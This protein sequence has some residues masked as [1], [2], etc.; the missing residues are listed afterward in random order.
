MASG[1]LDGTAIIWSTNDWK[2]LRTL[3][4]EHGAVNA[5]AFS[6]D[7][8]FIAL[9]HYDYTATL[10]HTQKAPVVRSLGGSDNGMITN[11]QVT[12][13]GKYLASS[14]QNEGESKTVHLWS[15]DTDEVIKK[16]TQDE[17][18]VTYTGL[19][20]NG[21]YMALAGEGTVYIY[22]V[23]TEKLIKTF[24]TNA[25]I[26]G[27]SFLKDNSHFIVTHLEYKAALW[28]IKTGKI[29]QNFEIGEYFI[30]T[31]TITADDKYMITGGEDGNVKFWSV[32]TGACLK[33]LDTDYRPIQSV[34]ISADSNY[35]VAGCTESSIFLWS[36][37]TGALLNTLTGHQGYIEALAF[38]SDGQ[39]LASASTDKI[40]KL[41]S[42][43]T[44]KLIKNFV[45]H[46]HAIRALTW[47]ADGKYVITG[48]EY[49]LIKFWNIVTDGIED[50][51]ATYTLY[52]MMNSFLE[53]E[54]EDTP[55]YIDELVDLAELTGD[56]KENILI[57]AKLHPIDKA[58][59]P[60]LKRRLGLDK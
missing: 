37:E 12:A 2:A 16:F 45:G 30:N 8:N 38:S 25:V 1:S 13:D 17:E 19:S 40:V 47:S 10:W 9:A 5:L 35:V 36:V 27:F 23:K 32:E 43:I 15:L 34:A 28:S 50:R 24:D 26:S 14:H 21:K 58:L 60:E 3:K 31:L 57:T 54:P 59:L 55:Q 51:T 48:D 11:I 20:T 7:K 49:G 53:I 22:S 44:F 4:S 42:L 52:E 41:W 29:V 39:Y 33:T 18:P 6:A 46:T 56:V